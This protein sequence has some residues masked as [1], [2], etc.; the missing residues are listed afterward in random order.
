MKVTVKTEM[1][2]APSWQEDVFMNKQEMI[3]TLDDAIART[4]LE[5]EDLT[6]V[7]VAKLHGVGDVY[8]RQVMKARKIT[9]KRGLGSPAW[10]LRKQAV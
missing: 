2:Y 8:V 3:R 7:E 5:R 4:I 6:L 10:K 1:V 9:R